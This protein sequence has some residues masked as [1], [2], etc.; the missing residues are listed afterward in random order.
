MQAQVIHGQECYL[1]KQQVYTL[2]QF[3]VITIILWSGMIGEGVYTENVIVIKTHRSVKETLSYSQKVIYIMR[4]PIKAIFAEYT[5][6]LTKGRHTKE[7]TPNH[8]GSYV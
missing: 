8:Y 1:K 7:A 6:K 3:T 2:A 5:R 4:N